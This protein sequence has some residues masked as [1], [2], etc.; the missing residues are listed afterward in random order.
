MQAPHPIQAVTVYCS[1]R[2]GLDAA[3]TVAAERL[4]ERLARSGRRL[5]YG[6][7]SVGLMGVLARACRDA[8]GR[9]TGV[10]T[11]RLR[12]K[13]RMDAANDENVVVVTMRE[14]KAIMERR[15]DAMIVLPGG[16]GTM[17]E[18]FEILVGRVLGEHDK[19]IVVISTPDPDHPTQRG[20]Y[21][22]LLTMLDHMIEGRFAE[23]SIRTLFHVCA[24][25]DE[26]VAWLG[27]IEGADAMS[28]DGAVTDR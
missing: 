25:P 13:E 20:Y 15:G 1:A 12:E 2:E 24:D 21:Q 3:Y 17:E 22:P 8:G 14:R 11:E 26:A 23:P 16:I 7:G 6:G 10:I 5:I 27:L 28:K 19:P 18:F 4:G 9:V